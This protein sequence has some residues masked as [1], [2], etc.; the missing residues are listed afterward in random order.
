M[1]AIDQYRFNGHNQNKETQT[2]KQLKIPR[3]SLLDVLKDLNQI[4]SIKSN[5][6]HIF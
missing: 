2:V 3:M 5:K 1:W 6:I 4:K